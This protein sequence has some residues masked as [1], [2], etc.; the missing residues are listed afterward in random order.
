MVGEDAKIIDAAA[1]QPEAADDHA[2]QF[3]AAAEQ[4]TAQDT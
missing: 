1:R 4:S 2:E 3:S